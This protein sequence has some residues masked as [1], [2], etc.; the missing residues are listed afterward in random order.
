MATTLGSKAVGSIVKI[1]ENGVAKDYLVVHQGGLSSSVYD[2]S[3][4]GTWLLRKDLSELRVGDSRNRSYANASSEI[5]LYLENTWINVYDSSIKSA[6]K[7]VKIPCLTN[8]LSNGLS[9][10]VFLLSAPEIDQA[11]ITDHHYVDYE[12]GGCLSYFDGMESESYKANYNG[13]YNNNWFTRSDYESGKSV[14]AGGYFGGAGGFYWSNPAGIRPAMILPTTLMV[15]D[16]SNV[17]VNTAP[18]TPSSIS[19]PSTITD[20]DTI[21]VS[22]GASMDLEN[23]LSGYRLEKST[24]GGSS[25]NQI[26]QGTATS[27]TDTISGITQVMY[28]VKAYDAL[29][30][31]SGYKT[32]SNV[33]IRFKP[34]FQLRL[35]TGNR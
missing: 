22:W 12:D 10:K 29:G 35:V 11:S 14:V 20:G 18:G 2:I 30:L 4:N 9:A 19:V 5:R 21:T 32:S 15:D 13:D 25:W 26:Y 34:T 27:K 7:Q 23:N 6:I 1:K 24:N 33:S 17:F 3:C 31:E 16:S 8:N 28:R